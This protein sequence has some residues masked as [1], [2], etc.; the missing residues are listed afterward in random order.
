MKG[1]F[2]EIK[3]LSQAINPIWRIVQVGTGLISIK[4]SVTFNLKFK[5]NP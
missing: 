1:E 2:L 3:E 5:F 4:S